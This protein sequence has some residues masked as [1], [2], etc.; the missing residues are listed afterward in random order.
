MTLNRRTVLASLGLIGGGAALGSAGTRALLS[1]TEQVLTTFAA[2]ELDL[3]LGWRAIHNGTQ[4]ASVAPTQTDGEVAAT[5]DDVKPGDSGCFDLRI[6]NNTNPAWVWLAIGINE[7]IEGQPDPV[8]GAACTATGKIEG[9][10]GD[11]FDVVKGGSQIE[12]GVYS[13]ELDGETVTVEVSITDEKHEDGDPDEALGFTAE[14]VEGSYG[15]CAVTVKSST[16]TDTVTFDPCTFSTD[17]IRTPATNPQG[18]EQGI[19]FVEFSV[20]E[21][22]QSSGPDR[23]DLADEI[24]V[25]VFWD[26]DQDCELDGDE[27]VLYENETLRGLVARTDKG[28]GG[29]E[30]DGFRTGTRSLSVSWEL[31]L[32]VGNEIQGDELTLSFSVYAEQRRHNESPGNPW[33]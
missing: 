7:E 16:T 24:V 3:E 4:V 17:E 21:T 22:E 20:C 28:A 25:D 32:E 31:P 23:V 10:D 8:E 5:F 29:I 9:Y 30:L 12:P 14:V 2:G 18:I 1:D 11:T 26:D 33:A 13:F 15:L 6:H 19:S 27:R